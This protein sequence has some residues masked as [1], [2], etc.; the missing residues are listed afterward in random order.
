M[1]WQLQSMSTASLSVGAEAR[2]LRMAVRALAFLRAGQF[3]LWLWVPVVDGVAQYPSVVLIGYLVAGAWS[4]VLFTVG[5]RRNRLTTGWLIAD[6]GVAVV[7]A[8]VVNRSF[9][10]VDSTTSWHNWVLAPVA[11]TALT[12]AVFARRWVAALAPVMIAVAFLVGAWPDRVTHAGAMAIL[13]NAAVIVLF[14]AAGGFAGRVLFGAAR[15]ADEATLAGL[16]AQ[17][18][19][20]AAEARDEER[21]RQFRRLHDNVLHTLEAIARGD[22]GP[23]T[24]KARENCMRDAEYLRGLINGGVDGIPTDLGVA[25]AG[26][27]RDRSTLGLRINQQFNALP[28]RIPQEVAEALTGAAREALNNVAKHAGTTEAWL[29]A[30]GDGDGGV[31]VVVAD[32]GVGFDPSAVSDRRGLTRSVRHRVVEIGGQARIDS[33]P[34]EGTT[35]E[36]T[37]TP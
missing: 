26:M 22:L 16:A 30:V 25:L 8:V 12:C 18:R 5:I 1:F 2:T 34:G 9:A 28:T 23:N 14:G 31:T 21:T 13:N 7:C 19:E 33:A 4:A 27:A 15:Q 20:A 6:A 29:T 17:R 37:W 36:M 11:G 24:V 3:A 10:L 32:Q 35:V